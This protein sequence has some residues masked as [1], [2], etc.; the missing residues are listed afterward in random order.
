VNETAGTSAFEKRQAW[1]LL[2]LA[3]VA[4][5]LYTVGIVIGSPLLILIGTVVT[6]VLY[7]VVR[8][9]A[10]RRAPQS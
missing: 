7:F 2:S 4:A 9:R 8:S 3:L 5:V 6:T 1:L 10:K